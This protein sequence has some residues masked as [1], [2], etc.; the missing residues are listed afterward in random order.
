MVLKSEGSPE[1]VCLSCGCPATDTTF[2]QKMDLYLIELQAFNQIY[3]LVKKILII[4]QDKRY[5]DLL[6]GVLSGIGYKVFK[7]LRISVGMRILTE[8]IPDLILC[9]GNNDPDRLFNFC[10][11]LRQI[12][13]TSSVPFYVIMNHFDEQLYLSSML[14]GV[15]GFIFRSFKNDELRDVIRQIINKK[16]QFNRKCGK[17]YKNLLGM[18]PQVGFFQ[19][20]RE[21]ILFVNDRFLDIVG[22][23]R[24]QLVDCANDFFI[25]KEDRE[26]FQKQ[27]YYLFAGIKKSIDFTSYLFVNPDNCSKEHGLKSI[28][29]FAT[30]DVKGMEKIVIGTLSE[31]VADREKYSCNILSGREQKVLSLICQGYTSHD[32]AEI[33]YISQR[34]V[35][36]H[37]GRIMTKL[38]V[39]NTAQLVRYAIE[40]GILD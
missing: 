21:R 27:L 10:N 22:L 12:E 2:A 14:L 30:L 4:E 17:A 13:V 25:K 7:T 33:L 40:S 29:I 32:I 15:D 5:A 34:T 35:Q 1:D 28:S 18:N 36:G 20:D 8:D 39:K 38:D 26:A 11:I 23:T 24:N 19:M 3:V 16:E 9:S 6:E 31:K 37:R